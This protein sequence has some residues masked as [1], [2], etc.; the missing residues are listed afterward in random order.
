MNPRSPVILINSEI[1]NTEINEINV[2]KDDLI[3]FHCTITTK[4]GFVFTGESPV[5]S[6]EE[7]K[8][9]PGM[10]AEYKDAAYQAA[11]E[12]MESYYKFLAHENSLR[13]RVE[14]KT[15]G[16]AVEWLKLGKRVTR[17]GWN[18]KGM[19]LFFVSGQEMAKR[20]GY[21]FGQYENEP[22]WNSYIVMKTADNKL[23]PWLASQT[24]VLA[25]D[26]EII[27]E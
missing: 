22:D 11:F 18:G 2:N 16:N 21:G 9:I 7:R 3:I 15:F 8:G 25:E 1:A 26:W 13:N 23:V 27:K 10:F 6:K 5:L 24:D 14:G 12:K 4:N 17:A 20:T 19:Y